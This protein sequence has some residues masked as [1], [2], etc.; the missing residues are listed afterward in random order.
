MP[1]RTPAPAAWTAAAALA[2]ATA[3][4]AVV[5]HRSAPRVAQPQ[6][7]QPRVAQPRV[8]QPQVPQPQVPQPQAVPLRAPDAAVL[9]VP[10]KP[11][12]WGHVMPP[13]P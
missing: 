7:S 13:H 6:V 4:G 10:T 1:G 3:G 9:R 8:A 12:V 5:V 2:V 11:P